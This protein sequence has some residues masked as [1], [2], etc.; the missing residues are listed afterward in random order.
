VHSIG[1][2]MRSR[3]QKASLLERSNGFAVLGKKSLFYKQNR[4]KPIN[5]LSGQNVVIYF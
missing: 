5:E 3:K 1:H 2:L 4:T